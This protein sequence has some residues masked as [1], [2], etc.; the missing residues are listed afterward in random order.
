MWQRPCFGT[1][2]WNQRFNGSLRLLK[3]AQKHFYPIVSSLWDKLSW[4]TSLLVGSEILGLFNNTL[5]AD[6]KYFPY[7]IENF[8]QPIFMS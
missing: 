7:N 1:P 4:K 8:P 3:S 2:F 5:T 6:D